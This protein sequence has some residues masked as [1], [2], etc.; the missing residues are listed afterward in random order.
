VRASEPC[1]KL[2]VPKIFVGREIEQDDAQESILSQSPK[3]TCCDAQIDHNART[4]HWSVADHSESR[5]AVELC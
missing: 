1:K 5:G 4:A 3:M 2:N